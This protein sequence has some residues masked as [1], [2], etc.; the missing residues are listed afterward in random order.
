MC[1]FVLCTSVRW[2]IC[3]VLVSFPRRLVRLLSAGG[4]VDELDDEGIYVIYKVL[5]FLFSVS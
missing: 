4:S 2:T 5:I 1:Y 3:L